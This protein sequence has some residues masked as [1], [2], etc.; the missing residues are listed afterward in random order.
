MASQREMELEAKVLTQNLSMYLINTGICQIIRQDSAADMS[1]L[2]IVEQEEQVPDGLYEGDVPLTLSTY[3]RL[4]PE[5]TELDWVT[6]LVAPLHKLSARYGKAKPVQVITSKEYTVKDIGVSSKMNVEYG[7]IVQL[8]GTRDNLEDYLMD[9]SEGLL[10]ETAKFQKRV[11]QRRAEKQEKKATASVTSAR[12]PSD[13]MSLGLIPTNDRDRAE[14]GAVNLGTGAGQGRPMTGGGVTQDLIEAANTAPLP[15]KYSREL[16]RGSTGE[17]AAG[18]IGFN[19]AFGV[20]AHELLEPVWDNPAEV[21]TRPLVGY[22]V[23]AVDRNVPEA[24]PSEYAHITG[25]PTKPSRG[26]SKAKAP[27]GM[28]RG[29]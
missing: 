4:R 8:E 10:A 15:Q 22:D 5:A 3:S 17:G 26:V 16:Y 12:T 20:D 19:A 28:R 1:V 24:L 27:E 14:G 7:F 2:A 25:S 23:R 29:R 18:G 13:G 9:L 21:V 11:E 6:Y